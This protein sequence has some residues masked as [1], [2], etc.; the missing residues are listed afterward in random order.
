MDL[1]RGVIDSDG[2]RTGLV[3]GRAARSRWPARGGGCCSGRRFCTRFAAPAVRFSLK[4]PAVRAETTPSQ[5]RFGGDVSAGYPYVH[6]RTTLLTAGQ[7]E[8]L[9]AER[10]G[11]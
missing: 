10:P 9:S 2:R 1:G 11:L 3:V 8:L 4:L 7:G 6:D 5:L